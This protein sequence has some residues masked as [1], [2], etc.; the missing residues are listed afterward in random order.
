MIFIDSN[1]IIAYKNADD[2]NHDRSARIFQQLGDGR[3]GKG[4]I[5]E[6]IFI[7]VTTVLALK[8]NLQS[9]KEVGIILLNAAD[10]E[11]IKA[12]DVFEK[13]WNIF[14]NQRNTKFSFVDASNLACMELKEIKNIA[15]F[16]KDFLKIKSVKVIRE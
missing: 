15:T 14:I 13:S 12:S 16:D 10:I 8:R 3:Y 4:I 1:V 6:F 9:A 11:I 7:E 2:I 5:S